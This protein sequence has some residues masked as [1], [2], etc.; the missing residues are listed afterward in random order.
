MALRDKIVMR[1][2]TSVPAK[3]RII[4]VEVRSPGGMV[5][6]DPAGDFVE[7]AERTRKGTVR[8]WKRAHRS[9][10]V[11]IQFIAGK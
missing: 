9:H 1:L 7:I 6:M 3:E 5:T 11:S 4:E 8:D 10:V 2:D